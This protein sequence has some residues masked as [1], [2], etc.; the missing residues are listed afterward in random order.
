M[1]T[2]SLT[3]TFDF[4]EHAF[5]QSVP[6]TE[7]VTSTSLKYY[8]LGRYDLATELTLVAMIASGQWPEEEAFSH[9]AVRSAPR[10]WR[11]L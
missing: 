1:A 10:G 6:P 4:A 11:D 3:A 2:K 7:K 8:S 5:S 9:S